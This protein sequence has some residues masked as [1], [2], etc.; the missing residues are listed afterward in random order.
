MPSS[1]KEYFEYTVRDNTITTVQEL[2]FGEGTLFTGF[3]KE[4]TTEEQQA[5]NFMSYNGG[6]PQ[7]SST[8]SDK[9]ISY[10]S[11][12]DQN[13]FNSRVDFL[14]FPIIFGTIVLIPFSAVDRDVI[15][16]FGDIVTSTDSNTFIANALKNFYTNPKNVRTAETK[17]KSFGTYKEMFNHISVWI[18]TKTLSAK[19]SN[20]EITYEDKIINVTPYV[21]NLSTNVSKNG[22]SFNFSL[23]SIMG[24]FNVQ[25]NRWEIDDATIKKLKNDEHV[26]HS[27]IANSDTSRKQFYF[28]NILQENDL[29][30]IRFETLQSETDRLTNKQVFEID[31]SE[32]QFKNFDMIGLIDANSIQSNF[33]SN[34][35][36]INVQG[37]DLMKLFI[38][39]GVYFYPFDFIA[40][41]IFANQT[42]DDR[43]KRYDGQLLGRFQISYK[44]I[45]NVLKFIINAL[46]TIK[47]CSD[48]LFSNF[49]N[50]GQQI[51][52]I[53]QV[54]GSNDRRTKKFKLID[55]ERQQITDANTI[56]FTNAK[57]AD[58]DAIR[59][60]RLDSNL[61]VGNTDKQEQASID[62]CYGR[63]IDF[64]T[65]ANSQDA[66][67][68]APLSS[69]SSFDFDNIIL[70]EG[71]F[72]DS[73]YNLLYVQLFNQSN[74]FNDNNIGKQPTEAA[75]NCM[76]IMIKNFFTVQERN[77]QVT[78]QIA[79]T[80]GTDIPLKGIWQIIKLVIDS[81]IQ[82]RLLV[83]SSI[84]NEHGSLI[85]AIHKVCQEPFVEFFGDTIGDQY[86]LTVRK[87]PFDQAGFISLLDGITI[88]EQGKPK[89]GVSSDGLIGINIEDS[90]I[91]EES[92]QYGAEAFSWYHINSQGNFAG[93]DEMAFAYL[94]AVFLKE[95]ADIFGSRPLDLTTNYIPFYP[96]VSKDQSFNNA[97]FIK[98]GVLDLQYMIQSN[99]YL[100]FVRRGS[101]TIANG[102]R[103]IKR[104][105]LVRLVSTGEIGFV[106]SVQHNASFSMGSIERTT[107][108]NLDRIMVERFIKGVN[109]DIDNKQVDV[110]YFNLIDTD[111][112]QAVFNNPSLTVDEFNAQVIG[113][114]KV[115]VDVFNYFL[116]ARQFQ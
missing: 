3:G 10:Y 25:T 32:L 54:N 29:V 109:I 72:P 8:N 41:G 74:S 46:G 115:N 108:I 34:D 49:E 17:T 97:Y 47:I 51:N 87:P 35:V 66:L 11:T 103:R 15:T 81:T 52:P 88:D 58:L 28:H 102:N 45:D 62:L 36:T 99:A 82:N 75:L 56:I 85:N 55:S 96:L 13:T 26:A 70:K 114:W 83:D 63:I 116:N 9:I 42:N 61:N 20:G 76:N 48:D 40:G 14:N 94:R 100:P 59:A 31:K 110:S 22:G 92:L 91:L 90:D 19:T 27:H 71:E 38:E 30:F 23:D 12:E 112:D 68:P 69:W 39:D 16:L 4:G 89:S 18:W 67:K 5:N 105:T 107:T 1:L 53:F 79:T 73:L 86:Y 44:K 37:R 50:K 113:K 106:E 24:K 77:N 65:I 101:I 21:Y 111:I 60:S 2:L 57:Q 64:L 104:G 33:A 93:G 7:G 6:L 80:Q 84:G 98:Q 43:L 95:Y 78:T